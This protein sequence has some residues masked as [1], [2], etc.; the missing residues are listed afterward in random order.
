MNIIE[1]TR[2]KQRLQYLLLFSM[3]LLLTACAPRGRRLRVFDTVERVM[4]GIVKFMKIEQ[5]QYLIVLLCAFIFFYAAVTWAFT[6]I[7]FMAKGGSLGREG[8]MMAIVIAVMFTMP[9]VFILRN[10][11]VGEILA[12]LFQ[13][14]IGFTASLVLGTIFFIIAFKIGRLLFTE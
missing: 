11:D 14:W 7:N 10:R 1:K 13:G 2:F 5:A 4:D 9:L 6:S 8:Q 3:S 12:E